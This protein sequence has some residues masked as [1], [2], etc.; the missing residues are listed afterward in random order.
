MKNFTFLFLFIILFSSCKSD[1]KGE[2]TTG[3][4]T[5]EPFTLK[6]EKIDSTQFPK[7]IKYEGHVK[8]AVRWNDKLGEN[9]AFTTETGYHFN[10]KFDHDAENSS[11]AE[12]FAYHYVVY[13]NKARQ[14][15]RV[16]DYISDCPVDIVASFVKNTFQ[17]TDLDHNGLAE[18]WM[19]YK[20]ICHGDVSPS[21]MKIIMY[22]SN[23]KYA[24]RGESKVAVGI[25]DNGKQ[26]FI[27]GK[28]QLD[29]NFKNGPK[30]FKE[31]AEKLWKDNLMETWEE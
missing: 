14:T 1:K 11:D 18:V 12:L 27:G 3:D 21:E 25:D 26:Q 9:I 29:P 6:V 22:E 19:M 30:V 20:T 24:A 13:E 4:S 10:K 15:W 23:Q 28:Y 31:F 5:E 17:V 2:N 16:Y 8:S 7:Q